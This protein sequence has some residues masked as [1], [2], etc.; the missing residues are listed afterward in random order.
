M[1]QVHKESKEFKMVSKA[2]SVNL[3]AEVLTVLIYFHL[4]T[5]VLKWSFTFMLSFVRS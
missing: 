1:G 5:D 4:V 3:F 2:Y